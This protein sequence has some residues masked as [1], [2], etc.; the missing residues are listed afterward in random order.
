MMDAIGKYLISITAAAVICSI[1][2]GFSE[3][4]SV[5]KALVV[6][7]TNL[8]LLVTIISPIRKIRISD[9]SIFP[10]EMITDGSAYIQEGTKLAEVAKEQIIQKEIEAYILDRAQAIGLRVDV[11]VLLD[12]TDLPT[13]III[14]GTASP[15]MQ[16]QLSNEIQSQLGIEQENLEWNLRD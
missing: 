2:R 14:Q 8:F 10:K 15:Y 11:E 1:I 6:M 12:E 9:I 3:K 13:H 7:I 16:Q 4:L 5:S